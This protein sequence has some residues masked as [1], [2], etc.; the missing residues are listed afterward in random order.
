MLLH[1][2]FFKEQASAYVENGYL[3]KW[4]FDST[5][6]N[7][8]KAKLND[9]IDQLLTSEELDYVKSFE[10]VVIID[11]KNIQFINFSGIIPI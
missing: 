11:D 4:R 10:R 2:N 1:T 7:S 8:M 3:R 5:D 9:R 6:F